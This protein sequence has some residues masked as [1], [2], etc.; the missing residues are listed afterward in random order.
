MGSA[1][2]I[3]L[4]GTGLFTQNV[5]KQKPS[6]HQFPDDKNVLYVAQNYDVSTTN[7]SSDVSEDKVMTPSM[8]SSVL[9]GLSAPIIGSM[10]AYGAADDSAFLNG[11]FVCST[12]NCTFNTY[13]TLN[14]CP[15]CVETTSTIEIHE[16]EYSLPNS[17]LTLSAT[18]GLANMTSDTFYPMSPAFADLDVG[19]LILHYQAISRKSTNQ[20]PSAA[21]CV[22]FWCVTTH[23]AEVT[24]NNLDESY[25]DIVYVGL[26]D[27]DNA[28]LDKAI[29]TN[30]TVHARTQY[31]QQSNITITPPL[32]YQNSTT[33]LNVSFAIS[34]DAQRAL[35]YTFLTGISGDGPLL[36]G[37][38][39]VA[40]NS[41][42][43]SSFAA[44]LIF[45]GDSSDVNGSEEDFPSLYL[46]MTNPFTNMTHYMGYAVRM[47]AS[48]GYWFTWGET[49][50]N[51]LRIHVR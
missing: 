3:L 9:T 41:S 1:A 23:D 51:E 47:S 46:E 11:L 21:E 13:S 30:T 18:T 19:P 15:A 38:F 40:G 37:S 4:L 45:A 44:H 28:I 10:S 42:R 35:Q 6:P 48:S 34:A 31:G 12:E 24:S 29:F 36:H 5:V 32:S 7:S 14:V 8:L 16:D 39:E 27:S 20:G 26:T 49:V 22:A 25:L 43:S 50:T 17:S 33:M 2:V